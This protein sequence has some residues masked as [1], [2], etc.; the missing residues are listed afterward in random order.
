VGLGQRREIALAHVRSL[1]VVA[2]RLALLLHEAASPPARRGDAVSP[3]LPL[4]AREVS[5]V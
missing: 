4:L 1:P 2:I 5:D 3:A